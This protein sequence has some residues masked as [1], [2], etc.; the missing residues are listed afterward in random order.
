[1]NWFKR[2]LARAIENV[3]DRLYRIEDKHCKYFCSFK[4]DVPE[5]HP[6]HPY[7][8]WSSC[9]HFLTLG[10]FSVIKEKFSGSPLRFTTVYRD[11][12]GR[13]VKT[14][15]CPEL[16]FGISSNNMPV[17]RIVEGATRNWG[18]AVGSTKRKWQD[19]QKV[20]V[21]Q[22]NYIGMNRFDRRRS[23]RWLKMS[24]IPWWELTKF[25]LAPMLLFLGVSFGLEIIG[26]ALGVGLFTENV[27]FGS[28]FVAMFI[29]ICLRARKE[30][31]RYERFKEIA[32]SLVEAS[33]NS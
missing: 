16:G 2:H 6:Y 10:G 14:K 9:D 7:A 1:M 21:V 15:W 27:C 32:D 26:R 5:L 31:Q 12:K 33:N 18:C 28:A 30:S 24:I 22:N 17:D 23:A 4:N 11:G 19:D 20:P 8:L 29:F 25:A 13:K 3:A